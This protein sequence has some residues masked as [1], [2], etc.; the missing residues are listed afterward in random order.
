[1]PLGQ[2]L[3]AFCPPAP[4][5]RTTE[6]AIS[7]PM[8]ELYLIAADEAL[9]AAIAEQVKPSMPAHMQLRETAALPARTPDDVA[10]IILDGALVDKKALK[11][12]R[13]MQQDGVKAKIFLLTD[14]LQPVPEDLVTESFSKPLRLGHLLSRLQFH[15]Q[16]ARQQSL[17]L[18]FGPYRLDPQARQ[19]VITENGA[20]VRLTEKETHL[21]EY[22]GRSAEPVSRQE[23]LAAIW[24]YDGRIDT[25]TLETH[26]YRL[27]R[28][29]DP[30]NREINAI[31]VE[32]GA[33][34]LMTQAR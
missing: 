18:F 17:P 9:R 7:S 30:D 31:L 19:I 24:G 27:R 5:H 15:L 29:L 11:V 32:N 10:L 26:I 14:P 28:K 4:S 13:D 2:I 1:M 23:L 25:H 3:P 6:V 21:L 20:V 16:S 12:L 8:P 34:R 22:I 33:Y